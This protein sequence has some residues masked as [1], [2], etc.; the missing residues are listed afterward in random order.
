MTVPLSTTSPI[1]CFVSIWLICATF[2]SIWVLAWDPGI[3]LIG[4]RTLHQHDAGF[5]YGLSACAYL[6]LG[7]GFTGSCVLGVLNMW[8]CPWCPCE[9][10]L[11]TWHPSGSILRIYPSVYLMSWLLAVL[12][13][14]IL[15]VS[16]SVAFI[17]V[18]SFLWYAFESWFVPWHIYEWWFLL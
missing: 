12:L 3:H 17:C 10:W 7:I 5:Y 9:W 4:D 15:L 1:T 11:Y 6:I 2:A 8:L 13:V 16:V 14:S 18:M